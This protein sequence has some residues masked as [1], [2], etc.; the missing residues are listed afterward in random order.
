MPRAAASKI[1]CRLMSGSWDRASRRV[2][3]MSNAISRIGMPIFYRARGPRATGRQEKCAEV[4]AP[5]SGLHCASKNNVALNSG[6]QSF[7]EFKNLSRCAAQD[8]LAL[9]GVQAKFVDHLHRM[10]VTNFEAIVAAQHDPV[11]A[12]LG[13]D[14]FHERF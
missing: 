14:I 10:L 13:N 9:L 6:T 2:P 1:A 12:Y 3:S 11:Y 5:P 4:V 8:H 7:S